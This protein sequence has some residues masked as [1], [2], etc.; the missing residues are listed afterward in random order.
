VS[1]QLV[2]VTSATNNLSFTPNPSEDME[3]NVVHATMTTTA[4]V[5]NRFLAVTITDALGTVIT[6]SHSAAPQTASQAGFH[7]EFYQGV[8]RET[9]FVNGITQQTLPLGLVVPAGGQVKVAD[10][11]NIDPADTLT[12]GYEVK[13][14]RGSA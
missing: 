7:T 3:L 13:S 10:T 1:T 14:L 2:K 12:V 6:H 5:G 9:T 11:A 8:P 4:T